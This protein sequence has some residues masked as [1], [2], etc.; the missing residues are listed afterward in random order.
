MGIHLST[1]CWNKCVRAHFAKI[2]LSANRAYANILW[3]DLS[4]GSSGQQIHHLWDLWDR[5]STDMC[6]LLKGGSSN[7]DNRFIPHLCINIKGF[8]ECQKRPEK[9]CW[10]VANLIPG[11]AFATVFPW[12]KEEE[13]KIM[14]NFCV[15]LLPI[16]CKY[17]IQTWLSN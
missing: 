7:Y 9:C 10:H 2:N 14:L 11:I 17:N 5:G 16:L 13:W 4:A 1:I 6:F 8:S 3:E 15:L 12:E